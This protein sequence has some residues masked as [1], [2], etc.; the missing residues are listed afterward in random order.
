MEVFGLRKHDL[1]HESS[2]QEL[3]YEYAKII[4][5]VMTSSP[6]PYGKVLLVGGGVAN[7]TDVASTFK[8]LVQALKDFGKALKACGTTVWV[9]RGGPNYAE[10]LAQMKKACEEPALQGLTSSCGYVYDSSRLES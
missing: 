2:S 6:E 3:V 5:R 8:G 7:F 10:G 1:R 4:L 9:R